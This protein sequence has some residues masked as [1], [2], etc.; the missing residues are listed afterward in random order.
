M[1]QTKTHTGISIFIFLFYICQKV[2]KHSRFGLSLFNI[3]ISLKYMCDKSQ[4]V[5]RVTNSWVSSLAETKTIQLC[6][7]LLLVGFKVRKKSSTSNRHLYWSCSNQ[8]MMILFF[9]FAAALWF[10]LYSADRWVSV[11]HNKT[12]TNQNFH[13]TYF[14]NPETHVRNASESENLLMLQKSRKH[15]KVSFGDF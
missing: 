2:N 4:E 5:V 11:S 15:T 6:K 7:K 10:S 14:R 8:S 9:L 13:R 1:E 12:A 3:K